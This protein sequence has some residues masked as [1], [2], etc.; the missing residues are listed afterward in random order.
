RA[1]VTSEGI[2]LDII[3]GANAVASE[4]EL[5]VK[6]KVQEV[7]NEEFERHD[8][9]IGPILRIICSQKVTFSKPVTIQLPISLR[10]EQLEISDISECRVRVLCQRSAGDWDEIHSDLR[11]PASF[12]GAFV[13]FQVENFFKY[14]KKKKK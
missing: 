11:K 10:H 8:V 4:T 2:H 7:Q 1:T 12:D 3:K 9:F 13:W 5:S 14:A 6:L